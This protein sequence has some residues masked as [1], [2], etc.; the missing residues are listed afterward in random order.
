[1][2]SRAQPRSLVDGNGAVSTQGGRRRLF[3]TRSRWEGSARICA[4]RTAPVKTPF[5]CADYRI[6][7]YNR[8]TVAGVLLLAA[9]VSPLAAPA[10]GRHA[11][12]QCVTAPDALLD[13]TDAIFIG[14][15]LEV[16]RQGDDAAAVIRVKESFKGGLEGVVE[17]EDGNSDGCGWS[18]FEMATPGRFMVFANRGDDGRLVTPAVCPQTQPIRG[19]QDRLAPFRAYARA[20]QHQLK[21]PRNGS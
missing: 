19:W 1:M 16:K 18:V 10:S 20:Q 6:V 2:G 9:V 13:A 12:C 4:L 17:V 7:I 5:E 21:T 15:L 11:P 14:D 3:R 8:F